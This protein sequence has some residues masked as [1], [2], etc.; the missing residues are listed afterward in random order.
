MQKQ[1]VTI[2]GGGIVGCVAAWL[3][4][5]AG[6]TVTLYEQHTLGSGASGQALGVLTPSD[7]QRPL[8]D[9]QRQGCAAWPALIAEISEAS[10]TEAAQLYRTWPK[11]AQLNIPVLFQTF[12]S[13]FERVGIAVIP[14]PAPDIL[15][16]PTLWAAG[17]G[18]EQHL[19]GLSLRAGTACRLA[20]CGLTELMVGKG[21]D[22][23][24]LYA[25]PAWDGTVLL[26]TQNITLMS[27]HR[28]APQPEW[29]A[30]LRTRAGLL[31]APLAQAEVLEAWVGNRPTSSPRLPLLRAVSPNQ[32][33]VA[34]LGGIGFALA[35]VVATHWLHE[36]PLE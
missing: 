32:W 31:F 10:G 20:A 35:P 16:T 24:G 23:Q 27:P 9:L 28:G 25:V 15:N 21:N 2:I 29:L 36:L 18:N 8:D 1:A 14:T 26:G 19:P 33:A 3:A 7:A 5:Q 13:L 6:Y 30:E 17:W 34:G 11:G 4:H 12:R 22:T